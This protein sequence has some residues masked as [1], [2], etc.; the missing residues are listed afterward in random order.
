MGG[1]GKVQ[2]YLLGLAAVVGALAVLIVN[3]GQLRDA[4]CKNIGIFCGSSADKTTVV[5]S[6]T[7]DVESGGTTDNRSDKCKQHTAD[8]CVS[9]T[10]PSGQLIVG[11]AKFSVIIKSSGVFVDGNPTNSDPVGTSNIGWFID[12]NRNNKKQICAIVYARTS[13]CETKVFLQGKLKAD[14]TSQ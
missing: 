4:W 5:E 1:L 13:A 6:G 12:T 9:P 3:V 14:E 7:V 2:A 11:S 8:A 10:Q